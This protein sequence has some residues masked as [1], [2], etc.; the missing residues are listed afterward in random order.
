MTLDRPEQLL[1]ALIAEAAL[2]YPKRLFHPV[3]AAGWLI[4]KL[5]SQWNAGE[6]PRI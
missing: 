6:H 3:S 5:D 2:G 1:A 4:A